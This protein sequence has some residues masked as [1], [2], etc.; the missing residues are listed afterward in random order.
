MK[1]LII[2]I[3]MGFF[4]CTGNKDA[5][6]ASNTDTKPDHE[7]EVSEPVKN[8]PGK[9]WKADSSTRANVANLVAILEKSEARGNTSH[10]L[11]AGEM[12]AG[13][14]KLVKECR[15]KGPDHDALHVWLEDVMEEVKE[16][17]QGK[18]D[19]QESFAD[20]RKEV[21]EFYDDFN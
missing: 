8:D 12:Q 11:L 14:D 5:P 20:L 17:K 16:L 15:M 13:L 3:S 1:K 6:A 18:D 2:I 7:H 10:A 19:Y 9:K 4:A 21:N